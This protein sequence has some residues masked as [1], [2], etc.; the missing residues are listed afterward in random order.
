MSGPY[1][2]NP[3][4]AAHAGQDPFASRFDGL[5]AEA[6]AAVGSCAN[7]LRS[8]RERYRESYFAALAQ[9]QA[10]GAELDAMDRADADTQDARIRALRRDA[11]ALAS[12]VAAQR[13]SLDKLDVVE[14][15]LSRMWL[16]LEREDASLIAEPAGG[17][18]DDDAAMRILQ[19]QESE[20]SRLAMEIHDGPAQGLANAIFKVEFIERALAT[21]P[22]AVAAET[23]GLR[24]L[25]RRELEALRDFMTQLRPPLL[26]DLGLE[27]AMMEVMDRFREH[28]GVAAAA[29]L[30]APVGELDDRQGMVVLRV[31][32]EALQNVRKHARASTVVVATELAEEGWVLEVRDDGRGFEVDPVVARGRRVSECNSCG[33]APN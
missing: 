33:N 28:S 5:L 1:T 27:A 9:W 23:R 25:L 15:T 17:P 13:S 32:Q 4:E 29:D 12:D 10:L 31:T 30:G 20:R 19:A 8:V 11:E 2:P 7:T 21:D 22:A 6:S 3:M 16:F 26:A 14:R 18:A 24:E